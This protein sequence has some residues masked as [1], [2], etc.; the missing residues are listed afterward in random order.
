MI[1]F[2]HIIQHKHVPKSVLVV[3]VCLIILTL[4]GCSKKAGT[5]IVAP[6]NNVPYAYDPQ[7]AVG[8]DLETIENNIFEGLVRIDSEGNIQKAMA[9]DWSV[10]KN[11]LTYTFTIRSDYKW[12]VPSSA[13]DTLGEDFI[14]ALDTRV[15]AAD[16]AFGI[17]RAISPETGATYAYTL[18][19]VDTAFAKNDTT[20]IIKLKRPYD[21]LLT[22]L[23][24]PLC[25]PCNENFFNETAGR[26]GLSTGLI[27]SNGPFYLGLFDSETGTVTLKKNDLYKGDFKPLQ[28]TVRLY[29]NSEETKRNYNIKNIS[30]D[31]SKSIKERDW[32]V[33]RYKN[34]IKTFCLN[35]NNELFEKYK[36]IRLALAYST[37]VD[38]LVAKGVSKAEGV[39]PSTCSLQ[40]GMSYR[41]NA[42]ILSGPS[43]DL[44][45][46]AEIYSK[47]KSNNEQDEV[48]DDL[49]LNIK[50]VCLESDVDE[51]KTVIQ[52]WQKT[53]GV[54]MTLT[55]EPYETQ[56]E[57]DKVVKKGE[58]DIAYTTITTSDFLASEF[59]KSFTS[60]SKSNIINL[61]SY[62]YDC[63][64]IATRSATTKEELTEDII[65]CEQYLLDNAYLIP[66]IV[67][68]TYV[69]F[70]ITGKDVTLRPS[71]TVMAFYKSK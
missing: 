34:A 67:K 52:G 25:M 19:A 39:V 59:L 62:A 56:E 60:E 53:F 69:A 43:Y 7:I 70:D 58:Y 42:N 29:V 50:L 5:V 10:S 11:G 14:K 13:A 61:D 40:A 32:S 64:V 51:I 1:N 20:L 4:T 45:K 18:D 54:A 44:K 12:R 21:G 22:A 30:Y 36:S 55:L 15:T 9:T 49:S 16:F 28:D 57:L 2:E 23:A 66:T 48:P 31:E 17:N 27:L 6:I 47:L 38:A 68:D 41:A 26:Y 46:A 35:C 33:L 3:L 24:S 63:L 65:N 71:G 8:T 37:D